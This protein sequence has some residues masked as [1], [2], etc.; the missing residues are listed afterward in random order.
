MTPD[1]H[2]SGDELDAALR[3]TDE[4]YDSAWRALRGA[5]TGNEY[6][7]R[8]RNGVPVH[9]TRESTDYA[10]GLLDSGEPWRTDRAW[11][12]LWRLVEE[13]DTDPASD[14]YGLWPWYYD[15]PL[16]QM[17]A[18]DFNW[19][20]FIGARLVQVLLRHA[21]TLDGHDP[22][23]G[24]AVRAALHHASRSIRRRDV[25]LSYTNIAIMG[26][27]VTIMAG[28]LL[29]DD[30]LAAYGRDRLRRFAAFTEEFGGFAEYNS[31]T[32]VGVAITLLTQML[33]D[34][35]SEADREITGRLLERAWSE[36]AVR[37]HRPSG[38]WAGPH[39]RSYATLL[40]P[41]SRQLYVLRR[42]LGDRASLWSHA[43]DSGP[44]P[45]LSEWNVPY[46]CPDELLTYFTE[47]TPDRD[48]VAS[49][50]EDGAKVTALTRLR[51][52]YALGLASY[53]SLWAQGRPVIAYAQGN[54]GPVAF[55]PRLTYDGRD[56]AAVR[57]ATAIQ[58]DIVLTG[59]CVADD[60]GDHHPILDKP[61][62][63]RLR[64]SDLRLRLELLGIARDELPGTLGFG[65]TC[66][67]PFG[68][69]TS[70][71]VRLLDAHFCDA[72]EPNQGRAGFTPRIEIVP[73]EDGCTVDVVLYSGDEQLFDLAEV[74]RF[75]AALAFALTDDT[76]LAADLDQV[77]CISS[78][79][80]FELA[81]DAGKPVLRFPVAPRTA[82]ELGA[83]LCQS[84]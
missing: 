33:R 82:A 12:L 54:D 58:G 26:C 17:G 61:R 27:Y 53:G 42:G 70:L 55:R 37:W 25:T 45:S 71:H 7:T 20:D 40:T 18:P 13:Q 69:S 15:E 73:V 59:V 36:A 28:E 19:A 1:Q 49:V 10:L 4:Q 38:Q 57:I 30:E 23:L 21:D 3:L 46:R 44:A 66:R 41:G 32:Y 51:P 56:Y 78:G 74:G 43:P 84:T 83:L 50:R 31:P 8:L 22:A 76:D 79:E 5:K 68:S 60:I 72:C 62:A 9:P 80:H 52:G 48:V 16:A 65:E 39:L 64:A 75:H 67:I 63:G 14:T 34:L 47:E 11:Q 35:R 29:A 24:T 2:R 81:F 6:A 77:R